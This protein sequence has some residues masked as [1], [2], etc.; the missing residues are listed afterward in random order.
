V[1]S[2]GIDVSGPG[3]GPFAGSCEHG[4][5]PSGCIKGEKFLDSVTTSTERL[6]PMELVYFKN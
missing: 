1:G 3:L 5:L 6:C 4:N 2:C